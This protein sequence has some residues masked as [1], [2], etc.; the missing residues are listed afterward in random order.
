MTA[1][2]ADTLLLGPASLDRYLAQAVTLP[3]GGALNMAYHWARAQVPF[4]L[5]TRIGDDEPEVFTS[6]LDRHRIDA[7]A[8]LVA[9]GPS[10]SIDIT[11]GEDRQPHMDRFVEGV[12][13]RFRLTDG[14]EAALVAARRLHLVLVA[15]ALAELHRL[16]D[17]GRLAHLDTSGDF[18]SFRRWTVERFDAAMAH[19]RTGFIGWPGDLDDP[20][21]AGVRSVALERGRLVVVTLGERGVRVIDGREG[22]AGD[23]L[24]PVDAVRVRGTTVGCGDAFIAAFLA[25]SWRGDGL[26]DALDAGRA[27][28]AAATAWLRPLPDD[29]Y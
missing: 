7:T 15:P 12:W 11:I 23:R 8:D 25:A 13:Q 2:P 21:L 10:S 9:A 19:L 26:D 27:A 14:E 5:V 20:L 18:L 6:F 29:A 4:R 28:G 16:G 22:R 24:V 3:G 1:P 17:A